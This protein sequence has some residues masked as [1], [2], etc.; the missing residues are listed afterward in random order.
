MALSLKSSEGW[1]LTGAWEFYTLQPTI[2]D[3]HYFSIGGQWS[4][5]EGS[6]VRALYGGERAGLKCSGGVCRFFPGFEGAR[7]ELELRL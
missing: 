7:L 5:L 4:F 3:E 1:G 2:F 6:V